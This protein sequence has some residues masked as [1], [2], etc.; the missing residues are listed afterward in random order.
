MFLFCKQSLNVLLTENLN[1]EL[2]KDQDERGLR[3]LHAWLSSSPHLGVPGGNILLLSRQ[4]HVCAQPQIQSALQAN[5][6]GG[7][8]E[9]ANGKIMPPPPL[10]GHPLCLWDRLR[11]GSLTIDTQFHKNK[12]T[13]QWSYLETFLVSRHW[14]ALDFFCKNDT[15]DNTLVKV[16]GDSFLPLGWWYRSKPSHLF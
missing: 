6:W 11:E 12:F 16:F 2:A 7:E 10:C 13:R 8:E 4:I 14:L 3:R 1:N 9:G 5:P 15:H